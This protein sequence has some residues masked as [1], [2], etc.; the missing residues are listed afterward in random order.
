LIDLSRLVFG[1]CP[2]GPFDV[3]GLK[4][5]FLEALF[6]ST[7][8]DSQEGVSPGPVGKVKETN[9]NLLLK[10]LANAVGEWDGGPKEI[11]VE[12]LNKIVEILGKVPYSQLV[13]AQKVA[14]ATVLFNISCRG[15]RLDSSIRDQVVVLIVRILQ[16]DKVETEAVYRTLVGLGNLAYTA[17]TLE[18]PLNPLQSGEIKNA[19]SSLQQQFSDSRV[20]NVCNEVLVL[21]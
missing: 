15:R 4:A 20:Q 11:E 6:V 17:K 9:T 14:F 8:W 3:A 1:F 2:K 5:R 13:K 10:A 12:W 16:E 19:V 7:G 21:L 18:Q